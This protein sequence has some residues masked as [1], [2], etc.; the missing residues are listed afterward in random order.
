MITRIYL[1]KSA[2]THLLLAGHQKY[3]VDLLLFLNYALN[4]FPQLHIYV[5]IVK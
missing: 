3:I 4:L 5:A 1:Y 2:G